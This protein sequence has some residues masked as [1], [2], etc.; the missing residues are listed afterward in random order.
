MNFVS[1]LEKG[2]AVISMCLMS[3]WDLTVLL[4]ALLRHEA[5]FEVNLRYLL[6]CHTLTED[7]LMLTLTVLQLL[8]KPLA[9]NLSM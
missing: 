2:Q 6:T 3:L 4:F 7:Q 1:V 8:L 5:K 9:Q